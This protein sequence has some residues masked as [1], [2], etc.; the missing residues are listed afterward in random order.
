MWAL[1]NYLMQLWSPLQVA[2]PL[3]QVPNPQWRWLCQAWPCHL[4]GSGQP[5]QL[6]S[7]QTLQKIVN[8][9]WCVVQNSGNQHSIGCQIPVTSHKWQPLEGSHDRQLAH[10]VENL[11]KRF[12][13]SL[14]WVSK[15]YCWYKGWK[16]EILQS[17]ILLFV[18]SNKRS[19]PATWC[20]SGHLMLGSGGRACTLTAREKP[21]KPLDR[22]FTPLARAYVLF[23]V[24]MSDPRDLASLLTSEEECEKHGPQTLNCGTPSTDWEKFNLKSWMNAVTFTDMEFVLNASRLTCTRCTPIQF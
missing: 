18:P 17:C 23:V 8:W 7:K 21:P 2:A 4:S 11:L 3:S 12:Y 14:L 5:P 19:K 16:K 10:H 20:T 1:G 24:W 9:H 15:G 13:F 6:G 22:A